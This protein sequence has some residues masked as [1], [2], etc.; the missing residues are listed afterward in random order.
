MS[1]AW[2]MRLFVA[3]ILAVAVAGLLLAWLHWE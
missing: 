3:V 2:Y 1:D